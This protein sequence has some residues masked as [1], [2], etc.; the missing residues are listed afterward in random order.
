MLDNIIPYKKE[1]VATDQPWLIEADSELIDKFDDFIITPDTDPCIVSDLKIRADEGDQYAFQQLYP[2][3]HFIL[4]EDYR[5]VQEPNFYRWGIF[6]ERCKHRI[7]DRTD[8]CSGMPQETVTFNRHYPIRDR[9]IPLC[10]IQ[11]THVST[12]FIGAMENELF[13]TMIFGGPLH[14]NF[15]RHSTILDAKTRHWK[16]VNLAH[17]AKR[18]IKKHGRSY[19]KNWLRLKRVY[20]QMD[21]RNLNWVNKHSAM[22]ESLFDRLNRTPGPLPFPQPNIMCDIAQMITPREPL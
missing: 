22:I 5:I 11:E 3:P 15:W 10:K 9:D 17:E 16:A 8:I 6:L 4:T 18:Y 12:V 2:F 14:Q 20:K 1:N 13:E 7:I 19:K 21:S